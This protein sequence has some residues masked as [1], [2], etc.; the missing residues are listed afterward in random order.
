MKYLLP[1]AAL[2]ALLPAV[3]FA[4]VGVGTTTPD[5]KAALDVRATDKGLLIPRLSEAQRL[6]IGSPPQGLMVYQ[7]DG[8]EGFYYFGGSGR[9]A[10]WVYLNPAGGGGAPADNLGNHTATQS[11]NLA[12]QLLVGGTA[13]MPGTVGLRVDGAGRVGIGL[14]APTEQL[15]VAGDVK[16]VNPARSTGSGLVFADGTKQTTAATGGGSFS[17]PYTGLTSSGGNAFAVSNTGAGSGIYGTTSQALGTL[18]NVAGVVGEGNGSQAVGVLGLTT[19]GYA[20]R[21]IAAGSSGVGV[22][23]QGSGNNGVYGVSTS[24]SGVYGTVTNATFSNVAGVQ[25]VGVGSGTGV[26]GSSTSSSG[27]FGQTAAGNTGGVAGVEGT[28]TNSSGTGVLGT[29]TSGTGVRGEATGSSGFGVVGVASGNNGNGVI[30]N[31]SGGATGVTG[32]AS[33]TGRAGYFNQ[34]NAS[35][36]VAAVE[37][38]QNGTGP[39]LRLTGK[40]TTNN[41]GPA[42]MLPVAYGRVASDGTL[43]NSTGNVTVSYF[44]GSAS[45]DERYFLQVNGYTSTTARRLI[46]LVGP[47]GNSRPTVHYAN[48]QNEVCEIGIYQF[49]VLNTYARF[50]A[51]RSV[52]NFVIYDPEL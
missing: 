27:V 12:G 51:D 9:T 4:Q 5:A 17:L 1:V 40:V 33:G 47:T 20:V 23:G 8:A 2:L 18:T 34:S 6:A 46:V 24:S 32:Q 35:N 31:A 14:A 7:T 3:A 38:V 39:A 48:W 11:L 28:S 42:N 25:G 52:F 30:G 26:L 37:I 41:T 49:S 19:T 50:T 36:T 45:F 22:Y 21:G 16:I 10:A 44:P 15:E 13:A 29:T 43:V